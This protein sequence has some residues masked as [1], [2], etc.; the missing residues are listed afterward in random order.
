ML[1]TCIAVNTKRS[2]KWSNSAYLNIKSHYQLYMYDHNIT[3]FSRMIYL[4]YPIITP[5][6]EQNADTKKE[7]EKKNT[8]NAGKCE[9]PHPLVIAQFSVQFCPI[10]PVPLLYQ[11]HVCI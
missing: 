9:L 8:S 3:I 7:R 5:D 11:P 4:Q 6:L 10:I 2:G 1:N